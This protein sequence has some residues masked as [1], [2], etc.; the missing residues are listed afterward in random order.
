MINNLKSERGS[1]TIFVLASCLF[2]LI[3]TVG[4]QVYTQNKQTALEKDYMQVKET[5]EK[6]I[7][8][9]EK[10]YNKLKDISKSGNIMVSFETQD[11]YLIPTGANSVNISQKFTIDNGTN[12]EIQRISYGW[13]NNVG[14]EPLEWI[15]IP[16][17]NSTNLVQKKDAEVGDYYLWIRVIDEESNQIVQNMD[18]AVSVY[19]EEISI[20]KS[21]DDAVIT[22]PSQVPFYNKKIGQ[23]LNEEEAK[24]NKVNNANSSVAITSNYVYVEATDSHG[25][26]IYKLFQNL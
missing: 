20:A 2:F 13:S 26:K 11:G 22:Y 3:S 19:S 9:Q 10:I 18:N 5:Y 6:D 1:I 25:N 7:A 8:N 21:G 17:N 15:D 16:L 14:T 12:N 23:G 4:V 24:L